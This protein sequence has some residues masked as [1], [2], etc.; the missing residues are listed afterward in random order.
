LGAAVSAPSL[1]HSPWDAIIGC[2]V[3]AVVAGIRLVRHTRLHTG[4]LAI[5]LL[6]LVVQAVLVVLGVAFLLS[7]HTLGEGFGF[8]SGQSWHDLLFAL[9]LAMLAYTR[10]ETAAQLAEEARE[11]GRTL[12]RSLFSAI[13]LVV[14]VTVLIAAIGVSAYPAENGATELGTKWE[15]APL[16]GI[17]AAFEGSLP[18]GLVDALR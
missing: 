18:S 2:S 10:L 4:A 3:I 12:P 11:P 13:G 15:T 9:P 6:D 7:P 5:A 14:V 8:A 16:V 17:A 1:R